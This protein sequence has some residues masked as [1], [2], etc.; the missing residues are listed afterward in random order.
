MKKLLIPLAV[1]LGA[2]GAWAQ[3]DNGVTVSTDPARAAA[4]ERHAQE[5]QSRPA[6]K[7]HSD[8]D[9]LPVL[10]TRVLDPHQLSFAF[11]EVHAHVN[12]MLKRGELRHAASKDGNIRV[13]TV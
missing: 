3:S 11:S 12:F 10:F 5:L 7:P 2:A 8:A 9:L 1:L 4:V 6:P 13:E